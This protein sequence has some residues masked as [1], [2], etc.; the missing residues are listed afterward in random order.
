MIG[1]TWAG[2][3]YYYSAGRHVVVP[4]PRKLS[5]IDDGLP[6]MHMLEPIETEA[7]EVD[8]ISFNEGDGKDWTKVKTVEYLRFSGMTP[9]EA[10]NHLLTSY[11]EREGK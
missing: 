11:S 8:R 4:K 1:G 3:V 5:S 6:P 10:F 7:Y 9:R 2:R